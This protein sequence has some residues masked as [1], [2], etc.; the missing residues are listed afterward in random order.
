M[1]VD[2]YEPE[3][4]FARVPQAASRIDPVLIELDQRLQETSFTVP[5]P[6]G[7]RQTVSLHTDAWTP[8]DPCRSCDWT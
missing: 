4:V 5:R 2:R 6:S 3:D 7:L 8:L 1:L